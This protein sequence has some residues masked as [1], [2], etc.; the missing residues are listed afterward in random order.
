MQCANPPN[1]HV[2][3]GAERKTTAQHRHP[4]HHRSL[5][6][7]QQVVTPIEQGKVRLMPRQRS[8]PAAPGQPEAIVQAFGR[9]ADAAVASIKC[10]QL[11]STRS[12]RLLC[13]DM[14]S[15]RPISLP[16]PSTPKADASSCRAG[17]TRREF[18]ASPLYPSS[19]QSPRQYRMLA[20]GHSVTDGF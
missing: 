19:L 3:G 20:I 13:N 17:H 4:A 2:Q 10:S 9:A 6:L 16:L 18:P 14:T 11:S 12:R 8:A 1:R 7:G 5:F 15:S